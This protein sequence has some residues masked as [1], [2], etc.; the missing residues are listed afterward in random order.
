MHIYNI[1]SGLNLID[2][3]TVS[4]LI[5][6]YALLSCNVKFGEPLLQVSMHPAR[7]LK[8]QII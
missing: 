7:I 2:S 1:L 3:E 4:T 5:F 6:G 8:C